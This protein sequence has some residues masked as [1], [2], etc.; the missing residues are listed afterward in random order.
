MRTALFGS[1]GRVA[2]TSRKTSPCRFR[3]PITSFHDPLFSTIQARAKSLN[4]R[5]RTLLSLLFGLAIDGAL[6]FGESRW[7]M[8][9]LLEESLMLLACFMVGIGVTCTTETFTIPPC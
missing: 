5:F 7:E 4:E 6:L 2:E 8:S 9:P 1:T 3:R